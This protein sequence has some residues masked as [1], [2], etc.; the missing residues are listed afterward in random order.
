MQNHRRW[1]LR[2]V[3]W[4]LG[5]MIG[6]M[7]VNYVV[8]PLQQYRKAPFYRT[9]Y[10]KPL[11][12]NPGLART[13]DYDTVIIGSS[14]IQNFRCSQV[15]EQFGGDCLKL[16]L[17]G[18]TGYEVNLMLDAA[19]KSGKTKRVLLG[20]DVFAY[21]GGTKKVNLE[22]G[23]MPEFLYDDT[24]LNDYKYLLNID[25]LLFDINL[26]KA[27]L[28]GTHKR[29]LDPD[30]YGNWSRGKTFSEDLVLEH[31][32][33]GGLFAMADPMRRDLKGI[34]ES[35]RANVLTHIVANPEVEF[36]L[37]YPP[38]S[39]LVWVDAE[40][41]GLLETVLGF[42]RTVFESLGG[43]PNVR[44]HDFQTLREITWDLDNYKDL[45]HYAP[46]VNDFMAEAMA[47]GDY[48]VRAENLEEGL[49]ELKV[50]ASSFSLPQ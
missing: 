33:G 36:L 24:R 47:R 18:A 27:N 20:L 12:L 17:S 35:F 28:F 9:Y 6:I 39:V 13:H 14:M 30:L 29:R 11:Y 40:R 42:K 25:V 21:A 23:A 34:E 5:I 3:W 37:F 16:H 22:G 43:Y 32:R 7:L 31:W 15:E 41:K 8:D 45:T 48:R 1:V 50:Q 10:H 44:I 4:A 38:Y 46:R 49:G 2:T 19:L 26:M